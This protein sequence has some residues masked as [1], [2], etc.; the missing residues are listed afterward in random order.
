MEIKQCPVPS[1]P[2]SFEPFIIVLYP[3][4]EIHEYADIYSVL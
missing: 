3:I 2:H 4:V 1:A